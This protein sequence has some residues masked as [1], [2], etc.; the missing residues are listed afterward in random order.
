[1]KNLSVHFSLVVAGSV[2]VTG[3]WS[4]GRSLPTA[5]PHLPQRFNHPISIY[6]TLAQHILSVCTWV[7]HISVTVNYLVTQFS[8]DY[9]QWIQFSH[10]NYGTDILQS[11]SSRALNKGV[12]KTGD[13]A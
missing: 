12:W 6:C 13:F 2:K 5:V 3:H 8:T 1:M 10:T 4:L 11:T 9:S 7:H